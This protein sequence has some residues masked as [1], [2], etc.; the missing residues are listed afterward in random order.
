M[1]PASQAEGAALD[2]NGPLARGTLGW[3]VRGL[4]AVVF[5]LV[6]RELSR[7]LLV[8]GV[9]EIVHTQQLR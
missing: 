2:R 3:Y 4:V 6:I 8:A 7:S 9:G 5:C 1:H